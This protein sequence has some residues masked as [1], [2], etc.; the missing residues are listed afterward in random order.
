MY[1]IYYGEGFPILRVKWLPITNYHRAFGKN[2]QNPNGHGENA[3]SSK[4]SG[5]K[6]Y[7]VKP[8]YSPTHNL[9]TYKMSDKN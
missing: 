1:K 7:D 6:D 3:E 5:T 9:F 8:A 4:K 2:S